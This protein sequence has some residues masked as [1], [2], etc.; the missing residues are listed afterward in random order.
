VQRIMKE[1]N[2]AETRLLCERALQGL[3]ARNE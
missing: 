3:D 2:D 1:T